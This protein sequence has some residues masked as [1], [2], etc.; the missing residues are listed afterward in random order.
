MIKGFGL[1]KAANIQNNFT[2]PHILQC[3]LPVKLGQVQPRYSPFK[4]LMVF[5][6]PGTPEKQLISVSSPR[7]LLQPQTPQLCETL[8]QEEFLS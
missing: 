8:P 1:Y 3:F 2:D 4:L 6:E 5:Q 7:V